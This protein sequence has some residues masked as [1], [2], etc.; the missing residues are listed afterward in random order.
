MEYLKAKLI[1]ALVRHFGDDYRR[2]DHALQVTAWAEMIWEA[3]G[4]DFD[5]VLATAVLHDVGI[6]EA[7]RLHSSSAGPLQEQYGPAIV[8]PILEEI[9]LDEDKIKF[10]CSIIGS[11]HTS[12]ALK[13]IEFMIMWDADMM[14]N[15]E[16]IVEHKDPEQ[17]KRVIER[18][19]VTKTG[20]EFALEAYLH[21]EETME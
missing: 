16:E 19:F 1:A 13:N 11:H 18:S 17:M 20:R 12:G 15:L 10:A 7:E 8:K 6:T 3:E 5:V 9:G 14:V 2:I 4:G 21:E